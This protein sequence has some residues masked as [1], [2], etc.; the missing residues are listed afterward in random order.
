MDIIIQDEKKLYGNPLV[1]SGDIRRGI[2]VLCEKLRTIIMNNSIETVEK[3]IID[4][5]LKTSFITKDV[6]LANISRRHVLNTIL[7]TY[8]ITYGDKVDKEFRIVLG[9]IIIK[10]IQVANLHNHTNCIAEDLVLY[11]GYMGEKDV[12]LYPYDLC[13]E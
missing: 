5:L 2:D 13:G 4:E 9:S 1:I 8:R 10:I 7:K 6:E 11:T 3:A 12:I